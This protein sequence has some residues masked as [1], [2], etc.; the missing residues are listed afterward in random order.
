MPQGLRTLRSKLIL[1]VHCCC[2]LPSSLPASEAAATWV[3]N[4]VFV[5][6]R[7]PAAGKRNRRSASKQI[8]KEERGK[9]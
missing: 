1:A 4:C 9:F 8:N 5:N 2:L 7:P 6:L 3:L